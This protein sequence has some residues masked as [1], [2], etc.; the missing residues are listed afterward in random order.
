MEDAVP[1]AFLSCSPIIGGWGGLLGFLYSF[2]GKE[3]VD[4]TEARRRKCWNETG[5]GAS[6]LLEHYFSR[7]L[8]SDSNRATSGATVPAQ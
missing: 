5:S 2:L 6:G 3:R 7:P 1:P 8:F 4:D